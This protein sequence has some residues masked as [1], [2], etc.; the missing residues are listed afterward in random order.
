M[1][2]TSNGIAW[3]PGSGPILAA[4]DDRRVIPEWRQAGAWTPQWVTI[5]TLIDLLTHAGACRDA[6]TLYGAVTSA[7][8]GAPPYGAD[9]DRLR[10]S[11]ARLR[12]HLTATEFRT[13]MEEG[14]RLDR[15]QV[16]DLALEAID[17]AAAKA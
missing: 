5:R 2:H 3:S 4:Q 9:A 7:T 13:C 17:R 10:Q 6:A 12:D 8:T 1:R 15:R 11:A 16:I 14:R